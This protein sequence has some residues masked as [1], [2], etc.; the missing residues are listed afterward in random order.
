MIKKET[1]LG[2][3]TA[4]YPQAIPLLLKSGLHCIGCHMAAME[5]L[6]QGCSAHGMSKK[7]IE[8]LVEEINKTLRKD[9]K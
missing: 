7:E 4:K 3:I 8:K 5:T 6:E 1:T 2:E 9:K